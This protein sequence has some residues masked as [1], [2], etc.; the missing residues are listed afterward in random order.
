[1]RIH[2]G[3]RDAERHDRVLGE[4]AVVRGGIVGRVKV[5]G[6]VV[7]GHAEREDAAAHA[8]AAL[9]LGL[10][11]VGAR[12]VVVLDLAADVDARGGGVERVGGPVEAEEGEVDDDVL[13][14]HGERAGERGDVGGDGDEGEDDEHDDGGEED[15]GADGGGAR[16]LEE[17]G[18]GVGVGVDGA[19][20]DALAEEEDEEAVERDAGDDGGQAR[21]TWQRR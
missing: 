21:T 5:L 7:L 17:R 10:V 19:A 14:E 12:V 11:V 3:C 4:E 18:V 20:G 13:E 15:G 6:E 9:L 8:H 1:V 2:S 16:I